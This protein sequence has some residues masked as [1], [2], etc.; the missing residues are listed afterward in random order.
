MFSWK[1]ISYLEKLVNK[2]KFMIKSLLNIDAKRDSTSDINKVTPCII[3][4]L[5]P[6]ILNSDCFFHVGS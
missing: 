6:N 4:N 2:R 3:L 1:C 5:I